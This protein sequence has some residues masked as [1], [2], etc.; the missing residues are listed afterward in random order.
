MKIYLESRTHITVLRCDALGHSL[1][2]CCMMF[3]KNFNKSHNM[4]ALIILSH[5]WSQF[6]L[7]IYMENMNFCVLF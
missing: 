1:S 3:V 4:K 6:F 5:L 7:L 2:I